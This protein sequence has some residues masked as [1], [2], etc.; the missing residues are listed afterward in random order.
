MRTLLRTRPCAPALASPPA[1]VH[2]HPRPSSAL[3][4]SHY[5]L[6][7]LHNGHSART[8]LSLKMCTWS[9]WPALGDSRPPH[10]SG[11]LLKAN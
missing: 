10:Q 6:G 1:S 3:S 11:D 2:L 4:S 8:N 5:P 9:P 7:W